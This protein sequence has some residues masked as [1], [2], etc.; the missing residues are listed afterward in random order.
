MAPD[1]GIPGGVDCLMLDPLGGLAPTADGF[2][3]AA[4]DDGRGV[5]WT[6]TR[7]GTT[8]GTLGSLLLSKICFASSGL[9]GGAAVDVGST[10]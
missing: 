6:S 9:M 1:F 2:G 10:V 4:V 5:K 8:W 7:W 3:R